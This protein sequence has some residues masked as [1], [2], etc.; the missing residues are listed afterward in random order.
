MHT[1]E[2]LV[3]PDD[4]FAALAPH[5][6]GAPAPHA[7]TITTRSWFDER[8]NAESLSAALLTALLVPPRPSP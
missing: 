3:D 1:P 6:L 2:A 7:M 5:C 8:A 4:F